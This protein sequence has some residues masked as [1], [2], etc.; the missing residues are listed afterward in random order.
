MKRRNFFMLMLGLL[1]LLTL[2]QT[3]PEGHRI[4]GQ[5]RGIKDT[6]VVLAHYQYDPTHYVP[7]DT[8][9]VDANGKFVF[10]GK[11]A[12]PE[13]LYLV[14]LPKG[15]Y[16]D[17]I[18]AEQQF[19]FETDTANFIKNM[20]LTGSVENAAFYGYQQKLNS[21]YEEMQKL[22]KQPKTEA[23]AQRLKELQTQARTY[24]T[25]FLEQNKS[26]LTTRILKASAEPDVPTPP[27]AA[28]G[29]PDSL[30]QFA[31]YKNH[32]WDN[33]DLS[34]DR[35]LRTP[36]LQPKIDRYIKELTVQ[37]VD[38]LTKEAD[39]L[40]KK[41]SA[42][43]DMKTYLIWYLTSQYERPK[44][45]GTDGLFIHMVEKYW[46]TRQM[47]NI[48]SAT[49]KTVSER[50]AVLKPL[51]VGKTFVMPAVG[52][53]LARPLSFNN[54]SAADYTILFFYAPHCG[55]CREAAPKVKKF[56]D[57]PAGKGVKVVAIAI[58]D[59]AEDWKKFIREFKLGAWMH[60]YD[61]KQ[62][63]DFRRQY[64]VATTPTLYVLDRNK[65][66]IA[67]GLPAEQ[68]ED[69]L[70]FTRKQAAL[71]APAKSS[72]TKSATTKAKPTGR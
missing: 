38:S 7:K 29:R 70:G 30:W 60:G 40:V 39:Y 64:D 2:A 57:S 3:S 13:G 9:R 22:D 14:V 51:Q 69:F 26:L 61:H 20:K 17:I 28:N 4:A 34:D 31:Y 50:V 23:S 55:H 72:P 11:K 8:A 5:I 58:E 43:K 16:F 44:V 62:Q 63:I 53:T 65:K 66:I 67:R 52:D 42:S 54:L 48:D 25:D 12:L 46:L 1:P 10:Q 36:L 18:L 21:V 59:S 6:T 24:R 68:V 47:P 49:L 35:M 19:S 33:F 41:A 56:T 15:R 71:T 32:F 45:L 27:K 37:Q